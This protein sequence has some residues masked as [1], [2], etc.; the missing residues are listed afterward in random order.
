MKRQRQ[1]VTAVRLTELLHRAVD[2]KQTEPDFIRALL[3][4][5]VYVHAPRHDQ[6]PRLRLFQFT[7]PTGQLALPFF[8]DRSQAAIAAG[9]TAK[10]IAMTGRQL[11]ELTRGATL[12]LNPNGTSCTLYPEEIAALLDRDEVA[13]I[14][15]SRSSEVCWQVCAIGQIPGWL[16]DSLASLY[17]QLTCVDAAYLTEIQSTVAPNTAGYLVVLAV[18]QKDAERAARATTTMLQPMCNAHGSSSVDLTTFVPEHPPDWLTELQIE[19]FYRRGRGERLWTLNE[20]V[21]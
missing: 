12:V 6:N 10:I 16:I 19:P 15:C 5:I 1:L 20:V 8:S 14:E 17:V 2:D 3:D 9:R 13:I 11:F 18:A 21:N 4:A 7:M